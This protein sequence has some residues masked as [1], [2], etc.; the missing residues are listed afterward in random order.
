MRQLCSPKLSEEINAI[1]GETKL[2]PQLLSVEMSEKITTPNEKSNIISYFN[3]IGIDLTIDDFGVSNFS[4][5]ELKSYNISN[6]K[7]NRSIIAKI[8]HDTIEISIIKAII[9]MAKQLDITVIAQGV[10]TKEQLQF[11]NQ[12]TCF[13]VQG[14]YYSLPLTPEQLNPYLLGNRKF[15]VD[16]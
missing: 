16:N 13:Y 9:A 15:E 11:L 3:K 10:E 1:L 12:N 5:H 2:S 4:L 7:I 6:I 14:N 8:P